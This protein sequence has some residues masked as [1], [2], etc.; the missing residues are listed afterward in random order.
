MNF[1]KTADDFEIGERIRLYNWK[2]AHAAAVKCG[3]VMAGD[4]GAN[5]HGIPKSNW[6]WLRE[7]ELKVLSPGI[8][9]GSVHVSKLDGRRTYYI[10]AYLVYKV[11]GDRK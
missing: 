10:P 7:N 4:I 1:K 3:D 2:D 9:R 5:I 11:K 6:L 8:S